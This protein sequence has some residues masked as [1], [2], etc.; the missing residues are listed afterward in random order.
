MAEFRQTRR[1]P[2][3]SSVR[4]GPLGCCYARPVPDGGITGAL[5][6]RTRQ[7]APS[8]DNA[9]NHFFINRDDELGCL[10]SCGGLPDRV[11]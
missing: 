11:L 7:A 10:A 5:T 8:G 2:T 3:V 4:L 1:S 6:K 9:A